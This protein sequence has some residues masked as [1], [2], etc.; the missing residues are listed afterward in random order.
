[1]KIY[2]GNLAFDV[3]EDELQQNSAFLARWNPWLSPPISSAGA[4]G[5]LLLLK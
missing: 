1:M 2:V 5:A 3:T 4:P